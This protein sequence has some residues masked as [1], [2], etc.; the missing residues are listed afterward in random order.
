MGMR[1]ELRL[2]R[3]PI[4]T[5][6]LSDFE[7]YEFDMKIGSFRLFLRHFF[8]PPPLGVLEVVSPTVFFSP[9]QSRAMLEHPYT[10][11]VIYIYFY[12]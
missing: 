9:T 12:I 5:I 8:L 11:M 1:A 3:S 10:Q 7:N 4:V 6:H 2:E